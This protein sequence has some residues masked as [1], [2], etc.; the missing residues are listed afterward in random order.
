LT[1]NDLKDAFN[2]FGHTLGGHLERAF[3]G[4]HSRID[5]FNPDPTSTNVPQQRGKHKRNAFPHR[6]SFDQNEMAVG[7]LYPYKIPG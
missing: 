4:I 7:L 5:M 1:A 2:M 3:G 6:R